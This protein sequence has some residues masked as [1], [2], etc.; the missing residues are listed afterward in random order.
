[1]SGVDIAVDL[2]RRSTGSLTVAMRTSP[3]F[4][5][6]ELWGLPLQGLSVTNRYAPIQMQDLGGRIIELLSVG[7]LA[8]T[9]LGKPTEGMFSRLRR[10]GVSPSVDDGV[11]VP[12][13]RAGKVRIVG[14]VADLWR[15]GVMVRDGEKVSADTVIAAT[16]YRTGLDSVIAA[17]GALDER[18]IPPQYGPRNRELAR[19]GLHFVGYA[20]PLTGHLRELGLLARRTARFIHRDHRASAG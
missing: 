12:A 6:R 9:P 20:S 18:G 11:F 4:L 14:E 1:V 19:E 13:V 8:N 10:T 16:G 5:P 17:P 15:D 2:L 7:N 3:S